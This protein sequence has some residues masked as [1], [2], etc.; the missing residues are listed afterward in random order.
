VSVYQSSLLSSNALSVRQERSEYEPDSTHQEHNHDDGI[1]KTCLLK[2]D[3]EVHENSSEDNHHSNEQKQPSCYGF[4][5]EK[6]DAN[7]KYERHQGKA[8]GIVAQ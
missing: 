1:E 6:K 7:T 2:I 4:A 5:V 3:L 8:E